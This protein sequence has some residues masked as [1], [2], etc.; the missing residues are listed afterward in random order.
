MIYIKNNKK[1]K[2]GFTLIEAMVAVFILTFTIT[3]FLSVASSNLFSARYAK[4]EITATYLMQEVV[5]YVRNDRD[6]TV[7]LQKSDTTENAWSNFKTKY[8]NCSDVNGCSIDILNSVFTLKKCTGEI[9]PEGTKCPYLYY[10]S[11]PNNAEPFYTNDDGQN[12]GKVKTFFKRQLFVAPNAIN[13]NEIDVEVIVFWKNGNT[14][15]SRSLKT[16]LMKWQ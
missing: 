11:E 2:N 12:T 3:T 10:K 6:T 16:T 13:P 1:Y 8:V 14:Q 7:F 4:N 9:G 15:V 5:D